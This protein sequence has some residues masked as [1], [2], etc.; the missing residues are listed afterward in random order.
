[1]TAGGSSGG[2]ILCSSS[3][4][5]AHER[6]GRFLI[7]RSRTKA[8]RCASSHADRHASVCRPPQQLGVHIDGS[9]NRGSRT[10]ALTKHAFG[11]IIPSRCQSLTKA[12]DS[13]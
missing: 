9:G 6:C 7:G 8:I 4:Q 10:A 1:V 12:N 11:E 2:H 3:E 13:A 5:A